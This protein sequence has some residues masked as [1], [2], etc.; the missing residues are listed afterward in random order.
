MRFG[1]FSLLRRGGMYV[2]CANPL[3]FSRMLR[4]LGQVILFN[5]RSKHC[6]T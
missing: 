3:S 1:G 4:F 2:G 6:S 5:L